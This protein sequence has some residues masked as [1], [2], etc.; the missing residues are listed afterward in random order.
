MCDKCHALLGRVTGASTA[1]EQAELRRISSQCTVAAALLPMRSVG[2]QGK[3]LAQA[4]HYSS[5]I[6][7]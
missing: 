1:L 2:V 6:S 5:Y 3:T 7:E 4:A